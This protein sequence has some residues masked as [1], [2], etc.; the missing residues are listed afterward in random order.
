[1]HVKKMLRLEYMPHESSKVWRQ[2]SLT[3][4][5]EARDRLETKDGPAI[6]RQENW[7]A[8]RVVEVSV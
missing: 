1:M 7:H 2:S 8:F 6:A 5:L 4:H 3:A